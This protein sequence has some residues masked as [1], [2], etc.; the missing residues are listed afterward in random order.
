[1]TKLEAGRKRDA[2]KAN[3]PKK[4]RE[5]FPG[6]VWVRDSKRRAEI[7][8][9]A[10][11]RQGA[12]SGSQTECVMAKATCEEFGA[13]G[14]YIGIGTSYVIVGDTAIRFQTPT[15][16]AREIAIVDRVEAD[17][18]ATGVYHLAAVP[19]SSRLGAP[20]RYNG[21]VAGKSDGS[22]PRSKAQVRR[23]LTAGIRGS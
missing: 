6:V 7:K 5:A 21:E 1:M 19:P 18:F 20:R 15:T 4:L 14:A 2:S 3:L 8:V 13:A 11:H 9:R 22:R 10:R 12:I 23:H 16:L 17:D